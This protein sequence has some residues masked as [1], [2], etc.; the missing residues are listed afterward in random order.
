MRLPN[1]P[2]PQFPNDLITQSPNHPPV[3]FFGSSSYVIP[4]IEVLRKNFDLKLV[5]TTENPAMPAGKLKPNLASQGEALRS[6]P[7]VKYPV[8]KCCIE[9]KISY[10]SVVN[11]SDPTINHELSTINPTVAVLADF[12]L[13]IPQ[14]ILNLFPKGIINIHPSLLPKYRGPTPV[15]T[16]ILNGEKITGVSIMKLDEEIDHG[17]ILGQE[18]DKILDTD[19]SE[20]L[21]KRLFAKGANLLP[22]ILNLYLNDNLKPIAQDHEKSTFT[23]PLTRQDGYVDLSKFEARNSKSELERKIRGYFPW[24]GVWTQIRI[25]DKLLRIKFLPDNKI[26]VEGKKP[27]S[28]KDFLNGYP[29]A[30]ELQSLLIKL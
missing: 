1:H 18:K 6:Y 26:Q 16:A 10:H 25:N 24:P 23:K 11:L 27:M 3:V 22:E 17:P 9:N 29:G 7:V 12:G 13:I 30:K 5:L 19:T 15:Q 21:Y 2:T 20:S 8:V 14:Q 4:I 28:Y